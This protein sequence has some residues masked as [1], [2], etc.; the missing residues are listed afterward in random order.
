MLAAG[1]LLV[2]G[3]PTAANAGEADPDAAQDVAALLAQNE[4]AVQEAS[5]TPATDAAG[6]DA[7]DAPASGEPAADPTGEPPAEDAPADELPAEETPAEEVPADGGEA[8]ADATETP[9]KQSRDAGI[10]ILSVP[11]ATGN[12]AVITVKVGG[13]R[14][15]PSAIAPLA[16]VQLTLYNGGNGGPSNPVGQPWSVCTS[17]AQGDCSFIVPN[18]QFGGSNRDDQFW[19]VQTGGAPGYF[20]NDELAVGTTPSADEYTFRTGDQLRAGQTYSSQANFMIASGNSNNVASGGIWQNSR[21]NPAVPQQC[22]I[23]I[24]LVIDLSGS[25][26]PSFG[27]LQDAATGFVDALEG[28]PSQVGVYTFATTAPASAGG[29]LG[30]TPVSTEAGADIVRDHIDDFTTPVGATNWDQGLAQIASTSTLYDIALVIT[31]GNPTVYADDEGPGNRT[32]FREVE[33]GIF[34]ANAV[35]AKGT[36]V[37]AFGVG[38][39]VGGDPENLIAIS[40]PVLGDDYFQT[41]DYEAAGEQLRELALGACEGSISIVKQVVDQGTTGEDI[42]GATPTG[43]WEFTA[44][45]NTAGVTPATQSGTTAPGTG[46]VNFPLVFDGPSSGNLTV[47]ETEQTGYDIVTQGGKRAVCTNIG[48]GAS[49][50]VTNDPNDP[51]AFS[52]DLPATQSV[53]CIVYNRPPNPAASVN[54]V[55]RWIVNGTAFANGNQPSGLSAQLRLDDANAPWGVTQTGFSAGDTVEIDETTTI[56]G[57]DLCRV[58]DSA[59][60]LGNGQPLDEALPYEPALAAG[61]N[62]FTLTNTVECTAELTLKK[63]VQGGPAD[64]AGWQ[65]DSV[66][67]NGALAGPA[68]TTGV[69]APVTP[70]VRY[71]LTEDGDPHYRQSILPGGEPVPPSAGSWNCVQVD[72][73]GNTIP[74]FADG[75]N[76]GVTVPLGYRVA[77]TAVNQTATVTMFKEIP[78]QQDV[79]DWLLTLEAQGVDP[80]IAD[81]LSVSVASGESALVRPGTVYRISEVGLNGADEQYELTGIVCT[82]DG[83]E[84]PLE[85]GDLIT[86]TALTEVECT[87]TNTPIQPTLELTKVVEPAG[88][89]DPADWHLTATQGGSE[90]LAGDGHAG[91]ADVAAGVETALAESTELPGADAAF[92]AAWACTVDGEDVIV[93]DGVL[94]ALEL[95]QTAECVVTN[96]LKPITPSVDKTVAVPT[97]NADGTWTIDYTIE[98][99]NPSTFTAIDY[100]LVDLLDF[101]GDIEVLAASYTDPGGTDHDFADPVTGPQQLATDRSLAADSSETWTVRVNARVDAGA[102][103]DP[104]NTLHCV[105]GEASGFLNT[106]TL[107][108]DGEDVDDEAC[109]EPVEPTVLKTAGTAV[110]HGDGTWTLPYTITVTNP[111]AT[112]GVVYDLDDELGLAAGAELLGASVTPPP[113]VALVDGWTGVAPDTLLADDIALAGTPGLD[114]HVYTVE[115]LVRLV[116]DTPALRC[117]GGADNTAT[118]T[119]GNQEL[120]SSACVPVIPPAVTIDKTVVPG[121]VSQAI[122]G[123]WGIQYRVD[124]TNTGETTAIYSLTDTPL[125]ADAVTGGDF[126][127]TLDGSDIPWNGGV[128]A[129]NAVLGAG[130]TASYVVT[131]TG[132]VVPGP[133]LTDGTGMCPPPGQGATGAFNNEGAVTSGGTTVRDEACDTPSVPDVEKSGGTAAQQPDGSWDVSYTLT[134]DNSSGKAVFYDLDDEPGFPA[135]VTLN[136]YSVAE[137]SP[138][139]GPIA[140]DV[141]PVPAMFPIVSDRGI[142][143]GET[144]VYTVTINVEVPFGTIDDDECTGEPGHGFYNLAELTSGQLVIDDDDCTPV[145]EGGAPTVDKG[146]P[147]LELS[148]DGQWTAVY[149][150]TVTGNAEFV[151]TYTLDDTLRFGGAVDLV[152]A[153]WSGEGDTGEWADPAAEPTET[154]VATPRV[155]GVDEV[156]VYTVTVVAEVDAAAFED[157][158]TTTCEPT[159]GTPNVGFLNEVVMTVGG[160]EQSDTGCDVPV[161]PEIEK[162][163][164]GPAVQDGDGWTVSY[165]I[166]VD[167]PSDA[168]G[169]VYDLHDTPDFG[170]DVTI[171]DRE[172]TSSDVTVNPGWNGAASTDDLVVEDQSLP[173]STTHTFH[174]TIDFAVDEEAAGPELSCEGE[175]GKGLL[176]GAVVVAG[177]EWSSEGCVDVPVTVELQKSWVIDG[178]EPIAW[179]DPALPFGFDAEASLD[180]AA[181]GWGEV[182]GPRAPASTVQVDEETFI[183]AGC[184]LTSADGLGEHVLTG[185]VNVIDVVNTVE[186]TQ[187]VTLTKVVHNPHGGTAEPSDWIVSGSSENGTG[188]FSGAGFAAGDLPVDVGFLLDESSEVTG[189]EVAENW[190]CTASRGGPESFRLDEVFTP[191][192]HQKILTVL[193]YGAVIDCVI[194]NRDLELPADLQVEKQALLPDGVTSVEAGDTFDWVIGVWNNGPAVAQGAVVTDTLAEG[195]SLDLDPSLWEIPEAYGLDSAVWTVTTDGRAFEFATLAPIPVGSAAS[196]FASI[197]IPVVVDT[198]AA[199]PIPENPEEAPPVELPV[200]LANEAC[201]ALPPAQQE[202]EEPG[203]RAVVN[204]ISGTYEEVLTNNCDDAEV[205]T[206]AIEANAWVQCENDVP[207]LNYDVM[208]TGA[209]APGE[210]TITWMPDSTVYP[211][212]EPIVTT[213]PWEERDGRTIWPYGAVNEDGISIAWPGWRLAEEGDVVGEGTIVASWENMVKDS[214]LPSYAFADQVN[215]MTITFEINPSQSVLAVYPMATPACAVERDAS[216]QIV[217]TASLDRVKPGGSFDY[218]LRVTNPGL[219]STAAMELFDE[220]PA[221]LRVDEI[222]TAPAP[223][224]PRWDDC[225]VTGTDSAGY[226]GVLHCVLNGQI[227][228]TRPDA[229]DIVLEV[230]LHPSSSA[231]RIENTGEICWNEM[232]DGESG[233]A[234][235]GAVPLNPQQPILCDDSTAV[236]TV[237]HGTKPAGLAGTGF[238]GGSWFWAGGL[239]LLLGGIVVVVG[240]RRRTRDGL[241]I[242]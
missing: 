73:Q 231:T 57:R 75:I 28:T 189:Y 14:T 184:E 51:F 39:G 47:T 166:T 139:P 227:G 163:A 53:S 18:T 156:H 33:N 12:N 175:G 60:T 226:G 210:I 41:E 165:T 212:A 233:A 36:K 116:A 85:N 99:T 223:A 221:D 209:V 69:T 110:D 137:V 168:Q 192:D 89:A 40:G 188:D 143:A 119:S 74:G 48:T 17:D 127:V 158:S 102:F 65:L 138:N 170:G 1:A 91:P 141:A 193:R 70:A 187:T 121:S 218:T 11:P 173:A 124:V 161:R 72:A 34:S 45:S 177:G 129:E 125:F 43:G 131:V 44:A 140:T 13:D 219:G 160:T 241:P 29:T 61:L 208:T 122:D 88:V 83:Q 78:G 155:I 37:V 133:W 76:G 186:C 157:P 134:V 111:S 211:D 204:R 106:A 6:E 46:A 86:F 62:S 107:S 207:Y 130:Q 19:V 198:P 77:C 181:I 35:K 240:M 196:P 120:E 31:D 202:E 174:V 191:N 169:L 7:D 213:V 145:E 159:E 115:V 152:S 24:A 236:V 4:A 172:V 49:V 9:A 8:P 93:T 126:A 58:T 197:T 23:D 238:G 100:D 52:V 50:D 108:Y 71:A 132:L 199:G 178:G 109:A 195:L 151:S 5:E 30:I 185:A 84:V 136:D 38:D 146:D 113:G 201:V 117:P 225:A 228:G 230:T 190:S 82:L 56:T 171:T 142:G 54:V 3:L 10:G 66:G 176:N 164:D 90:V 55:K 232:P 153:E 203:P 59:V 180:G 105:P 242:E 206:K 68:G 148:G 92:D 205:P 103:A 194:E 118:V 42:T 101:G 235:S 97:A 150:I 94:P 239:L 20:T 27:D 26:A 67:P 128:L 183:P 87:L 114:A 222:T 15:A 154:I 182:D 22:G 224:F 95:A 25:V 79:S 21:N 167:N 123:T 96:T 229:P 216:P 220:I 98:A 63:T 237:L 215:P 179:D 214:A 64:P 147:T 149:E 234:V 81:Q 162:T 200:N 32:R 217:K 2:V 135:G 80:E 104:E 16:G 112:T 144:H